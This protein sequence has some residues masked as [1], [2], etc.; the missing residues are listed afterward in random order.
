MLGALRALRALR[1]YVIAQSAR[2]IE[3]LLQ[4]RID[5]AVAVTGTSMWRPVTGESGVGVMQVQYSTGTYRRGSHYRTECARR[6]TIQKS[7]LGA[8]IEETGR[9]TVRR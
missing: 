1:R 7:S 6:N 5:G 8:I 4:G 2:R 3:E 9:G